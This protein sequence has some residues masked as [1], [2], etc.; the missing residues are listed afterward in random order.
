MSEKGE[1]PGPKPKNKAHHSTKGQ[2]MRIS[3]ACQGL[4]MWN[5]LR[6]ACQ[7]IFRKYF[8]RQP[9][10]QKTEKED[11]EGHVRAVHV[12]SIVYRLLFG[13]SH[14]TLMRS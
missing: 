10:L 1:P 13:A 7:A 12:F 5:G 3:R 11:G 8:L 2:G 4:V 14:T 6:H 9:T